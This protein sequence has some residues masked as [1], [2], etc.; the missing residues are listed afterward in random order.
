MIKIN[1]IVELN[2]MQMQ[3]ENDKL[4]PDTVQQ[5]KG[6]SEAMLDSVHVQQEAVEPLL[7]KSVMKNAALLFYLS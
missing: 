1:Y 3:E 4:Q 2:F 6:R 5:N 7:R